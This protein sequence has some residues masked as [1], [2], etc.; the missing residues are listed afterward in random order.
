MIS[1]REPTSRAYWLA[2]ELPRHYRSRAVLARLPGI[3]GSK[4]EM[5]KQIFAIILASS[6]L[7]GCM[8]NLLLPMEPTAESAAAPRRVLTEAEKQTISE[9][10]SLKTQVQGT[11]AFTWAPLVVRTH[12]RAIDFC[13]IVRNPTGFAGR[14]SYSKYLSRLRFDSAGKLSNVSVVSIIKLKDDNI[15]TSLDFICIQD[16][17]ILQPPP[18]PKST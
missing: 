5:S 3:I 1:G 17:Y 12:D 15:P 10:V 4:Y 2:I 11:D 16:G 14:P 9:A 6:L 7:T 13:G 8:S 18:A